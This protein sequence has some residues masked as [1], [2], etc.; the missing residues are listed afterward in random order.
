MI[1][2]SSP[3]RAVI[4]A[5]GMGSRLRPLTDLRPKPLVEV[6]G[7][8]ILHNALRNLAAIG[9]RETTLVVGYRHETIEQHCGNSFAGMRIDY[10]ES[11]VFDRTGSAY[12]LWLAREA[13][14]RG[15]TLLLEGDVFFDTTLLPRL[16]NHD[17][18]VAA[19]D[20][21]DDTMSGSAAL[22]SAEGRVLEF[23]MSQTAAMIGG[24][25]LYKTVNIYRFTARTLEQ[26]LVP[27]LDRLVDGGERKCYVEQVL[28]QLIE[29]GALRLRGAICS[30]ARWFEIDDQADLQR[31]EQIFHPAPRVDAPGLQP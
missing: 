10:V 1:S 11:D 15:D 5:A 2:T 19:V 7:V 4:L 9:V 27:A 13:L 14:L 12:S 17:G 8:P 26:V 28:A 30:D 23:R 6:R 16:L 3:Y 25:P 29:S 31:A 18:D 21:F 24:A 22:V 20:R